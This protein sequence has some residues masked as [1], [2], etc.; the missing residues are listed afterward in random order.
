MKKLE[1]ELL[2]IV[3]MNKINTFIC[4]GFSIAIKECLV[5]PRSSMPPTAL[6]AFSPLAKKKVKH[7]IKR[8]RSREKSMNSC[9]LHRLA[10]G[11][12]GL[13][14][15]LLIGELEYIQQCEITLLKLFQYALDFKFSTNI[16]F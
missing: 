8:Y 7:Q 14:V 11:Q 4:I 1:D 2:P 13:L 15:L 5:E 16:I 10:A 12:A 9:C 3:P 6:Y